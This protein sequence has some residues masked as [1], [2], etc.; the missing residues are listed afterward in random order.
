MTT[1]SDWVVAVGGE[2]HCLL[3]EM[4]RPTTACVLDLYKFSTCRQVSVTWVAHDLIGHAAEVVE[5]I[6]VCMS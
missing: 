6:S 5:N 1:V 4:G 3:K 2:W